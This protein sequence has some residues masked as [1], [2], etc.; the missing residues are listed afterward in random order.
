M[1]KRKKLNMKIIV[2]GLF[3]LA[4]VL[5]TPAFFWLQERY[6]FKPWKTYWNTAQK[7]M[8]EEKFRSADKSY[9]KAYRS[10][11]R[12]KD[13]DAMIQILNEMAKFHKINSVNAEPDDPS[14]HPADWNKAVGCWNKIVT[15]DPKN[16]QARRKLLDYYYE[17]SDSRSGNGWK[18]VE[19]NA[20]ELIKVYQEK[21][22]QVDPLLPL[23][24]GQAQLMQAEIGDT[25]NRDALCEQA[26]QTL[27]EAKKGLPKN[28]KVY[29][30]IAQAFRL[31]GELANLK[32]DTSAKKTAAEEAD[33]VLTAAISEITDKPDARIA[34]L[35]FRLEQAIRNQ[36]HPKDLD[37]Q[38]EVD[39]LVND[40]KDNA[41]VQAFL[42][43]YYQ[44]IQKQDKAI[45]AIQK[46]HEL[47][48][49]KFNYA[50]QAAILYYRQFGMTSDTKESVEMLNKA[51]RMTSDALTYPDTQDIPGPHQGIQANRRLGLYNYLAGWQIEKYRLGKDP[52]ILT[53]AENAIQQIQQF[54]KTSDNVYMGKW[55]GM[56][57]LAKGQVDQEAALAITDPK[58]KTDALRKAS[59][60]ISGAVSTLYN[61]YQ[62]LAGLKQS[63]P[64]LS[65]ALA[66]AFRGRSEF[67]AR[68]EFLSQSLASS[69]N[70]IAST[71]PDAP[72]EFAETM[73]GIGD[74]STAIM[75]TNLF[76][77][78]FSPTT[79]SLE[80]RFQGLLLTGQFDEAE[81]WIKTLDPNLDR[82]PAYN[83]MLVHRRIGSL[84]SEL[85]KIKDSLNSLSIQ[86][87]ILDQ[88]AK[89]AETQDLEQLNESKKNLDDKQKQFT[90][91]RDDLRSKIDA[92]FP[93]RQTIVESM[94]QKDP[95]AV[96]PKILM[97]VCRQLANNKETDKAKTLVAD[98]IK[99]MPQ[100]VPMRTFAKTLDFPPDTVLS[101]EQM[102]QIAVT[103]IRAAQPD[104]K[105]EQSVDIARYYISLP[106]SDT[107]TRASNRDKARAELQS[108]TQDAGEDGRVVELLF[109]LALI[110]DS[111]QPDAKPDLA[112]ARTLA[113]KAKELDID[114][115]GGLYYQAR[116]DLADR[117]FAPAADKLT[118]CIRILP[119]FPQAFYFRAM[120]QQALGNLAEA[121]KD[122]DR[123]YEWTLT[124]GDIARLRAIIYYRL[125]RKAGANPTPEEYTRMNQTLQAAVVLNPENRELMNFYAELISDREPDRALAI[126]QNLM[127]RYPSPEN[128]R[129]LGSLALRLYDIYENSRVS[130]AVGKDFLLLTAKKALEKAREMAPNDPAVMNAWGEYLR[131]S[132]QQNLA[133]ST[134]PKES[135][136]LVD[137]YLNDGKYA[138]AQTLL[139][140]LY[141]KDQ[142]DLKTKSAI[143][144]GLIL[145]A[146]KTGDAAGIERYA[147][148]LMDINIDDPKLKE[149]TDLWALQRLLDARLDPEKTRQR[150]ASFRERY[151]DN[152]EGLVLQAWSDF[153]AGAFADTQIRVGE[154]L[155]QK[156]DH[157][158]AWRIRGVLNR[159]N[160]NFKEAVADL[161]KSLSFVDDPI[162]RIELAQT[163][164]MSGQTTSAIGELLAALEK[165]QAPVQARYFLESIYQK[166]RK[167]DLPKFYDQAVA[168]YSDD[169]YWLHRAGAYV[170]T[171]YQKQYDQE[172]IQAQKQGKLQ[173]G[174]RFS[175][176]DKTQMLL[177]KAKPLLEKSWTLVEEKW[178]KN[179]TEAYARMLDFYL[180]SLLQ[181]LENQTQLTQFI[182]IASKYVTTPLATIAYSQM[183]QAHLRLGDRTQCLEFFDKALESAKAQPEYVVQL[184]DVMRKVLE[185][186]KEVRAWCDKTLAADAKHI[187]AN[188]TMFQLAQ[189]A[190]QFNTAIEYIDRCLVQLQTKDDIWVEYSMQKSQTLLLA[191]FK[192]SDKKYLDGGVALYESIYQANPNHPKIPMILNNLAFLLADNNQQ[193]DKAV[194]YARR[195]L[196]ETPNDPVRMDTLA[197]ALAKSS[198]FEEAEKMAQMSIQYHEL[199][200]NSVPWDGFYHL[201]MAQEGLKK[202]AEAKASYQ[203][204]LDTGGDAIPAP[205]KEQLAAAI[206]RVSQ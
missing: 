158:V 129:L 110:P 141:E 40:F 18:L 170:L 77:S 73:L 172:K 155:T 185:S 103:S 179:P 29:Q 94:M 58:V 121:A 61:A 196:K 100:F 69:E 156:P 133:E 96:D 56:L 107:T 64:Q 33:K 114:Q 183:A 16:T 132:G 44:L 177:D 91:D 80:I 20:E 192:T 136:T 169:P 97:E 149:A 186:D 109:D 108:V 120:A 144:R 35:D 146:L 45:E 86:R 127:A 11:T 168:K 201:G 65:Y 106:T 171:Q 19:T 126:R 187:G 175:P 46:A 6:A 74:G 111:D 123:A 188:Y 104:Q 79:R 165:P 164:V 26:I 8:Q 17:L 21:N 42:A 76:E 116:I 15:L 54:L 167:E 197:Y 130:Q 174:V 95:K 2:G 89:T 55:R 190:G 5:G 101:Q 134:L 49:T 78:S 151:P 128:G 115:C 24:L 27:Q 153:N 122:A 131:V 66:A 14:Y 202:K 90:K 193:L 4:V 181:G 118:E 85:T 38:K 3:I 199:A 119:I 84:N 92:L 154:I 157:A 93:Q 105:V 57:A 163:Y 178:K 53:D 99:T 47:D 194:E 148:E 195:A 191:F 145:V 184:L 137:F 7:E 142:K 25:G 63:D 60:Q 72:L 36:T 51:I 205:D 117:Q 9:G 159:M 125:Y 23:F 12:A 32:G 180:E 140:Q 139:Q 67:G 198:Q 62:Q 98:Y 135:L 1:A 200:G 206:K 189:S 39:S 102:T 52:K 28:P 113:Q 182:R 83:V 124:D 75:A 162:T 166:Y 161:Q 150:V 82:L 37:Q 204:A 71:K 143:L 112:A 48:K 138:K 70:S 34:L 87:E 173:P 59:K 50:L 147:R 31:K 152:I 43:R 160:S 13:N 30:L 203:K 81:K 176:S 88:A 22:E 10:A 41:Q 68:M